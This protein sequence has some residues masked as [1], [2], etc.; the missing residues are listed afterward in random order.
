MWYVFDKLP[1]AEAQGLNNPST[2]V[3]LC[4]L[5]F[6]LRILLGFY[7]S[8]PS[9]RPQH[10]FSHSVPSLFPKPPLVPCMLQF[11][12]AVG[13]LVMNFCGVRLSVS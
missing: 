4:S 6:S 12:Q 5:P 10:G 9:A 13:E 1:Q 7:H 3:S 8:S 11:Y 2:A